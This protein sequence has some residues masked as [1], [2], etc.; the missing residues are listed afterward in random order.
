[1]AHGW[2]RR[3][4]LAQ[5]SIAAAV[6]TLDPHELC[7]GSNAYAET[8]GTDAF[9][10]KKVGDGVWAAVAAARYK[11]NSNAAV[12]ETNDGLVIVDSHSKPS[13]AQTL[14]REVQGATKK[15]VKKVINTHFHWD[16]WQGNQVYAEANPGC[17]IIASDRCKQR[18]TDPD[19]T[20]GGVAF[21]DKQIASMPGEIEKLKADI[22]KAPDPATRARLEGNLAQAEA[23]LAELKALKP[24]VPTRTVS[25]T[26]TMHEGGREIRLMLLGR[27]HT[28]G[29][30]FVYLPKEKVVA[31]GDAVID[32]M[33]FFNDGYPEDWIQTVANLERLDVERIIVGHG[34]P[35]TRSHL[36]YFR[37]YLTDIVGAVKKAAADGMPLDDMKKTIAADLAPKYE[38]SMSK[39]PLGRYRDRIDLN[40]EQ[41]YLKTVKKS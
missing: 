14:Y 25:S 9:D 35:A 29:D 30:L 32:W 33:P 1:M 19:Q 4:I 28:D 39:Y 15:P 34:E 41:V 31:T 21:V 13:A 20:N 27:A 23:Y 18:L 37:G 3:Q 7:C 26:V 22:Q 36:A 5:A 17:E 6:Y 38:A 11:V 10:L 12:I 24:Q 16:H 40:V 2:T 8:A